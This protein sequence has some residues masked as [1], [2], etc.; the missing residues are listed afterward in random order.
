MGFVIEIKCFPCSKSVSKSLSTR[1]YKVVAVLQPISHDFTELNPQPPSSKAS[2]NNL[3]I[4]AA[5]TQQTADYAHYPLVIL[6]IAPGNQFVYFLRGH[7]LFQAK[8]FQGVELLS[9]FVYLDR[10]GALLQMKPEYLKTVRLFPPL[11]YVSAELMPDPILAYSL[12]CQLIAGHSISS[13]S[14][15]RKAGSLVS[16]EGS[17]EHG[18]KVLATF[19]L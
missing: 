18:E 2:W 6:G 11:F 12:D 14:N 9:N 4:R 1:V 3:E 16:I 8:S 17:M 7:P 5:I 15:Q 19:K 13:M 10:S